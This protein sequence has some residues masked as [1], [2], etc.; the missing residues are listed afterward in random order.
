MILAP[1]INIQTYLL[2]YL[3]HSHSATADVLVMLL[4]SFSSSLTLCVSDWDE[5]LTEDQARKSYD[6]MLRI[7]E[8]FGDL[9]TG[10]FQL[11][12]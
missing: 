6:K 9:F 8:D 10:Y 12:M 7:E 3:P 4:L 2:T 1:D 11:L 5:N